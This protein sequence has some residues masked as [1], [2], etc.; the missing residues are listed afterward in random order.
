MLPS[1]EKTKTTSKSGFDKTWKALGMCFHHQ[2]APIELA[3]N[4]NR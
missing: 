4:S 1:W 2:A 3:A